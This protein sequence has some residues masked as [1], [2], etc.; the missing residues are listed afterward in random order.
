MKSMLSVTLFAAV[1]F[2]AGCHV[3]SKNE[4]EKR[5]AM[6]TR[7][8]NLVMQDHTAELMALPGVVGVYIGASEDSSLCIK[9]MVIKR[10]EEV[11]KKIPS[12]LEGHAVE[13]DETGE[14][15]PLQ[16]Q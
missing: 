13:I 3:D 15:R 16:T 6:P 8:I 12:N 7:D 2:G 1:L 14:I 9:V 11:E 5:S 4:E 10:T